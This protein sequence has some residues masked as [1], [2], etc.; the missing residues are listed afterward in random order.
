MHSAGSFLTQVI[1]LFGSSPF[2]P[3]KIHPFGGKFFGPFPSKLSKKWSPIPVAPPGKEI[4][5][6]HS[7][8]EKKK[9]SFQQLMFLTETKLKISRS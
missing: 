8:A 4:P 7:C 9:H 5:T 6:V 1:R 2:Q 3:G